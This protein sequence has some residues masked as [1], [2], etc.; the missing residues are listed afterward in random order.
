MLYE[1]I[2]QSIRI[3]RYVLKSIPKVRTYLVQ[4]MSDSWRYISG[5]ALRR[6]PNS[7]YRDAS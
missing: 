6:V 7:G 3:V 2:V 5:L 1:V 4:G